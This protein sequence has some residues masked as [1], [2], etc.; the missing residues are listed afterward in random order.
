MEE[1][2]KIR[3]RDF[4]RDAVGEA[5]Y[6]YVTREVYNLLANTFKKEEHNQLVSVS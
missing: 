4:Y 2:I 5:E 3:I 1:K 6:G